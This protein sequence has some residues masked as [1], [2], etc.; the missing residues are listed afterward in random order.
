MAESQ[1]FAGQ[2]FKKTTKD[3]ML[4]EVF[5]KLYLEPISPEKCHATGKGLEVAKL[6]ERAT[7]LVHVV[8]T[9]GKACTDHP[10]GR[11][12]CELVSESTGEKID[13]SVKKSG[14]SGLYEISYQATRRGRHQLH[15]KVVGEHIIGSPFP[16]FVNDHLRSWALRSRPSLE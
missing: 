1:S 2:V 15:I 6:G 11:L 9:H 12:N 7:A 8:D 14:A 10:M 13:G 16:V 3:H 4:L 5:R